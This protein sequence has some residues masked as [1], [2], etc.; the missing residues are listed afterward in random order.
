MSHRGTYGG[1]RLAETAG[2]DDTSFLAPRSTNETDSSAGSGVAVRG[3][4]VVDTP[5]PPG[6]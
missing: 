2:T 3:Q 6:M 5:A 1:Q 4:T